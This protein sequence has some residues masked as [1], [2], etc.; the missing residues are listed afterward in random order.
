MSFGAPELMLIVLIALLFLVPVLWAVVD[1]AGR[2]EAAWHRIGQS[3]GMWIV[4]LIGTWLL[5]GGFGGLI[6]AVVYL[7]STR[8]KLIAAETA[9]T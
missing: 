5:C 4:V 3:R 2:S 7:T 1:A 8:P 6:A 9:V